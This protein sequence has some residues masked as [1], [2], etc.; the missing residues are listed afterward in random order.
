MTH[1]P[2]HGR[3]EALLAEPFAI[4]DANIEDF[5]E[6]GF[7]H[8]R[9]VLPRE[10]LEAYR[11]P[12][13]EIVSRESRH[14]AP[15]DERDAYSQSF[16]QIM[17]IWTRYEIVRSFILNRRT[18]QI[19]TALL[20]TRG[21][22]LW[23]DQ[24]LFKEAGG[25][26]TAWH[27]DQFFWPLSSDLSVTAWIPLQD[28]P[29]EYGALQFA[30]GSHRVDHGRHHAIDDRGDQAISASLEAAGVEV[31]KESFSLGDIS[32]HSGWTFHR[33]EP[34]PSAIDRAAVTMIY[35]D[36]DMRIAEPAN[37][38]QA[39]DQKTWAPGCAVGDRIASDINPV[40]YSTDWD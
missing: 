38:F 10:L 34:N 1:I 19:A 40:L 28:T 35:I 20:G 15:M 16:T 3:W 5:R 29:V 33:A 18:A 30:A 27:A 12:F 11:Q 21:V 13:A 24:A 37:R 25:G 23:H 14:H 7:V 9:G 26:K 2:N 22:R 6:N 36:E 39:H 31:V 8:L 17:N 32:F 4:T